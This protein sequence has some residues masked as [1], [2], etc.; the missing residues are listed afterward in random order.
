MKIMKATNKIIEA[1]GYCITPGARYPWTSKLFGLKTLKISQEDIDVWVNIRNKNLYNVNGPPKPV[2]KK[3]QFDEDGAE[4]EESDDEEEFE[5]DREDKFVDLDK[6][7][8]MLCT[9]HHKFRK[10]IPTKVLG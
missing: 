9:F 5:D 1:Y 2:I 3:K 6:K 4:I 7:I 8:R 10:W